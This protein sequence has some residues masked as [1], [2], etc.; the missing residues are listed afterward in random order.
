MKFDVGQHWFEGN[1]KQYL[2]CMI[3]DFNMDPL[4]CVNM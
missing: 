2:L 3:I 1:K 4:G